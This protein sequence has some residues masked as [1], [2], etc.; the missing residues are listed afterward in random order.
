MHALYWKV[1]AGADRAS[2]V[3]F[4][5]H[6]KFYP[7]AAQHI[8][9]QIIDQLGKGIQLFRMG[10]PAL[11]VPDQA[12]ADAFHIN[13]VI[14]HM[15]A[16]NLTA[17]TVTDFNLA[18]PGI[19]ATADNKMIGETVFHSAVLAV[20]SI[21]GS[22]ITALNATVMADNPLPATTRNIESLGNG[23][24]FRQIVL[25]DRWRSSGWDNKFLP[26]N[27]AGTGQSIGTLNRLDGNS[28][29]LGNCAEGISRANPINNGGLCGRNLQHLSHTN[30]VT[31]D[32]IC[33]AQLADGRFVQNGDRCKRFTPADGVGAR[34]QLPQQGYNRQTQKATCGRPQPFLQED[35]SG[36]FHE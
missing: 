33:L 23:D 4:P 27:D 12:N 34:A 3:D 25:P 22:G 20:I 5:V 35:A 8:V 19:E 14:A 17:P 2:P 26:G 31:T 1:A 21:I 28:M 11:K 18:T 10:C 36:P 7:L 24:D 15:A 16:L 6:S 29:A 9:A 13:L 30:T 32:V